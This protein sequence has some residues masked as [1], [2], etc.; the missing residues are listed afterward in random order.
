MTHKP[1]PIWLD[2]PEQPD[3]LD[4]YSTRALIATAA[5]LAMAL[6]IIAVLPW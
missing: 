1:A 6:V 4:G 5:G 2:A 3:P